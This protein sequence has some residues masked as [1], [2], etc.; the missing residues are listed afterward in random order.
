[1]PCLH[2]HASLGFLHLPARHPG[3]NDAEGLLSY[4]Y[5]LVS[6]PDL[7]VCIHNAWRQQGAFGQEVAYNMPLDTD[8]YVEKQILPP[9]LRIFEIFG[10]TK[11]RL[12]AG[13]AQS[14]LFSFEGAAQKAQTQKSLFDFLAA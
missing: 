6:R 14:N 1:M 8:Y 11:D 12:C 3:P 4:D 5:Y 9:V 7:P 13:R 10:V 2:C